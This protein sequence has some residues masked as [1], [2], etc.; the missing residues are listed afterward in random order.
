MGGNGS[1][2]NYTDDNLDSYTAIWEG[3]VNN[4]GKK[5]HKRVVEALRHIS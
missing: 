4:T 1:D 2:L 5:D 3:E